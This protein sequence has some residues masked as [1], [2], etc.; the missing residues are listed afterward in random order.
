MKQIKKE[1]IIK[2]YEEEKLFLKNGKNPYHIFTLS[3]E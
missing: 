2:I 1:D 3:I